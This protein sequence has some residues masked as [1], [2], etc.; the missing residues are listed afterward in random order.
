MS[1]LAEE[2]RCS[3]TRIISFAITQLRVTQY[4]RTD[5]KQIATKSILA[6]FYT[7]L[8]HDISHVC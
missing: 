8:H 3:K 1:L 5:S 2:S 7:I 4:L 6:Q